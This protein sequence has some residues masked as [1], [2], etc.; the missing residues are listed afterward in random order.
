MSS[1]LLFWFVAL[2]LVALALCVVARPLLRTAK[3]RGADS[4]RELDAATAVYRDQKRQLDEEFAAGTIT[5][6]ERATAEQELVRRLGAEIAK[7]PGSTAEQTAQTPWIA[8]VVLVA[9]V[10]VASVLMY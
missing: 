9:V 7:Q 5:A 1:V 2:A 3:L 4:P 8:I 10:P 6:E